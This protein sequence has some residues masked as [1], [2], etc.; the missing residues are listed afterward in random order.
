[1]T[2]NSSQIDVEDIYELSPMQVGMLFQSLLAPASGVFLE[3][4]AMRLSG[5]ILKTHFERTWQHVVDR[6]PVLRSSFH[7]GDLEK[8]VQVVHK[9][10]PIKVEHFDWRG[11]PAAAR[12]NQMAIYLR[13]ERSRGFE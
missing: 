2:D 5:T 6:T 11:I 4:Q 1:M 8:P 7:W 12:N 3:Q 13:G 10:V 9:R